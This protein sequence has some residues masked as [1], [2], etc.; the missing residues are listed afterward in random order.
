DAQLHAPGA[1]TFAGQGDLFIADPHENR[2]RRVDH[3]TARITTVVGDGRPGQDGDGGPAT[4][5][6]V[7]A[8]QGIGIDTGAGLD[9]AVGP[10]V[11]RVDTGGTVT[12]IAGQCGDAAP[13]Y[14]GDNGP[15]LRAH[16][17]GSAL[18][19]SPARPLYVGGFVVRAGK[20]GGPVTTVAGA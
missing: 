11:R 7:G 14:A 3:V 8:P 17:A 18:A 4:S 5:A 10:C 15:A 13:S 12:T 9:I 19:L 16:L 6:A 2:V 1:L 20:L